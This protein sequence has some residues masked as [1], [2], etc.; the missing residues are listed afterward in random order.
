MNKKVLL[1]IFIFIFIFVIINIGVILV[2]FLSKETSVVQPKKTIEIVNRLVCTYTDKDDFHYSVE[3]NFQDSKLTTKIDEMKWEDKKKETCDFYKK[4][5]ETYNSI[6][7][8]VDTVNCDD[9]SGD[10]ITTYNMS[11]L[12]TKEAR[13]AEVRYI[14]ED[15]TFDIAGYKLYRENNGYNCKAE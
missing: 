15:G 7:G 5:L 14:N 1:G 11:N 8:I 13:I 9:T 12:D 4:R 2:N 3:L 10:R 6:T